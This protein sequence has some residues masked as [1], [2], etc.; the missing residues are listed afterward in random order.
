MAYSVQRRWPRFRV[1]VPAVV[2][3]LETAGAAPTAVAGSTR[4]IGAG[5]VYVVSQEAVVAGLRVRVSV[6]LGRLGRAFRS[7]GSVVR[8]EECGFAVQFD[9][10]VTDAMHLQATAC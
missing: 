9:E 3:F 5:G 6:D 2:E 1:T 8:T 7:G 10:I 4:D